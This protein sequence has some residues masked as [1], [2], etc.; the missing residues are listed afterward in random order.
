MRPPKTV[1]TTVS[2][3][4]RCALA[5]L[6]LPLLSPAATAR[7]VMVGVDGGSWNLIDAM[8]AKGQLRHLAALA[9][10]G[11]TAELQTVE[12]VNSPTVWTSTA[13]GRSP[14]VHGV[15]DFFPTRIRVKVPTV[16]E[17]LAA[18][19]LR[20][21]LYDY[22]ITWPPQTF[23]GGFVIPGW[24]RRDDAVTPPDVW[25][26]VPQDPFVNSY[27]E[28]YTSEVYLHRAGLEV[29]EK[30]ARW[31]GLAE[32]FDL[33]VG[34][35]IFY[36][37]DMTAH[38]YW[39]AAFPGQFEAPSSGY[40]P[41]EVSA[42]ENALLGIDR[43]IGQI[44]TALGVDDTIIVVSDHGFQARED[45]GRSV[46]VTRYEGELERAGLDPDGPDFAVVG[47]FGAVAL[48]IHPGDIPTRDAAAVALLDHLT[49]YETVDGRPLFATIEVIDTAERPPEYAKPLLT[50]LRQW[51]VKTV[52]TWYFG[53]TLDETAH[54]VVFALP[55][56]DLLEELWPDGAVR[57]NG[58]E[59]PLRD[60]I[61]RQRFTGTHDP[62]AIFLAAGGPVAKRS[63]R[64][65][66]S[67]LDIAPLL[68]YLNG[69][70]LTDDLEG[71]LPMEMIA[72]EYLAANPPARAAAAELPGLSETGTVQAIDDP[73]LVEKLRALGY[74]E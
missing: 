22:L 2:C 11:V 23:P 68:L 48:R 43:S 18:S 14:E 29:R 12:P 25:S 45:G 34:A 4:A 31:N 19:G 30:A 73:Q 50:R 61:S 17:R 67:V 5:G 54:A 26:R 44:V 42:I 33:D 15:T 70:P 35:V 49:S 1:A 55:D 74:V 57:V 66:L 46:W 62:T 7:V 56:D 28:A 71:V 39:E 32:A 59:M 24:L 8:V 53:V 64:G 47:T 21:G 72:A 60:A 10:R 6:L 58:R 13:T 51:V 3:L 16:F 9:E 20:V 40:T 65:A 37:V 38:R 41:E 63:Q 36:A 52:T 27:D 69:R